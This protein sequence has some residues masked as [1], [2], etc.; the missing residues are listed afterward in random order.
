MLPHRPGDVRVLL[1][2]YRHVGVPDYVCEA[3][4]GSATKERGALSVNLG[5]IWLQAA[6]STSRHIRDERASLTHLGVIDG[7][8]SEA[9]DMHTQVGKRAL[10][11]FSKACE[12]VREYL[13][14]FV[15]QGFKGYLAHGALVVHFSANNYDIR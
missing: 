9:Y 7:V 11:Y 2:L 4:E 14:R 5:L 1:D 6:A 3:V 15:S 8:S 13:T 10:A 12:P